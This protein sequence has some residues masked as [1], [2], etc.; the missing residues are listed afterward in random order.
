MI[1][2]YKILNTW[3]TKE[4]GLSGETVTCVY[5]GGTENHLH[6]LS[7]DN[8]IYENVSIKLYHIM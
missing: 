4:L 2:C 1:K 8:V 3:F 7:Y 6:S 5:Y